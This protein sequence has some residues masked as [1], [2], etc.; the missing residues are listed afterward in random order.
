MEEQLCWLSVGSALPLS[1]DVS[2][3]MSS[4][5]AGV[6]LWCQRLLEGNL[7]ID[8]KEEFLATGSRLS[9]AAP[10]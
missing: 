5:S 6:S 4:S 9:W 10:V 8:E 1:T 7:I 2:P 3:K